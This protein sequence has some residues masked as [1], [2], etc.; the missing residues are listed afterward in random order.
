MRCGVPK[1][2]LRDQLALLTREGV[3]GTR[4]QVITLR[5]RSASNH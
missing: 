3:G 5:Q 2:R 4:S 1:K